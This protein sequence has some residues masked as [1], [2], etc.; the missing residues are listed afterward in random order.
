M[1]H[2]HGRFTFNDGNHSNPLTSDPKEIMAK[3]NLSSSVRDGTGICH[4]CQRHLVVF[5]LS[6]EG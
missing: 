1:I 4:D 5:G 3:L 6:L 2:L